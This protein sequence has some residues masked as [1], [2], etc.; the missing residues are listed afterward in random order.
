MNAAAAQVVLQRGAD[1]AN[2]GVGV[3]IEQYLGGDDN[4]R[5]AVTALRRLF[6]DEG[7][8]DRVGLFRAADAF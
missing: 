6:C 2:V 3:A 7:V 5:S 8:L 4:S 1:R